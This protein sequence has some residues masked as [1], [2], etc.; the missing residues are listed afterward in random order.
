MCRFCLS[1]VEAVWDFLVILRRAI[2]PASRHASKVHQHQVHGETMQPGCKLT[3]TA[4][5]TDLAN[6][7]YEYFLR[8]VFGLFGIVR[9]ISAR[10]EERRVGK[11]CR[12]GWSTY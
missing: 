9:H 10:S 2:L 1:M 12:C 3:L 7:V 6:Q 4:K 8:E 5:Q 11:E